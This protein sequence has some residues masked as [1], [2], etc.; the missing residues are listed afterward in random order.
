MQSSNVYFVAKKL[1]NQDLN[2]WW[3]FAYHIQYTKYHS[4]L[5]IEEGGLAFNSTLSLFPMAKSN[6]WIVFAT[7][8]NPSE[9][10]KGDDIEMAYTIICDSDNKSPIA[11]HIGITRNPNFMGD[12]HN[13]MLLV[14]NM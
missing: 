9:Q 5:Q 2:F 14:Q 11:T 6:I 13:Y 7:P 12:W 3:A 10:I 4:R 1:T 8:K